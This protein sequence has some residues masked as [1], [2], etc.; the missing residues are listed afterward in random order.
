MPDR[1]RILDSLGVIAN[2]GLLAA[3]AWHVL[4]A[5]VLLALFVGWRPTK[6]GAALLLVVPL[7]SVSLVAATYGNP[8]N[9]LFVGVGGL[10]L[11]A[12]G[13]RLPRVPVTRGN[14]VQVLAG[15]F[16]IA[17]GLGYPH[18]LTAHSPAI[19]LVAAPVGLLP[20]PTLAAVIGFALLTGGLHSRGWSAMLAALG[21]F[22]GVFGT[23]R[24][25]VWL[26][27]TLMAVAMVLLCSAW[28]PR[29]THTIKVRTPAL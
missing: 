7:L 20:C 17:V 25:D 5:S 3:V 26:D 8:F 24:L 11:L 12:L 14:P 22:Y 29:R 16:G 2:E 1:Q 28:L 10:A 6:R 4:I 15:I 23:F 13:A 27:S 19:Y 21:L 9:A 18:F